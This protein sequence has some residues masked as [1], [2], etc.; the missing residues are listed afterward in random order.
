MDGESHNAIEEA[1]EKEL[2]FLRNGEGHSFYHGGLKRNVKVYVEVFASLQDQPERRKANY[3]MLGRSTYTAQ[4]G[5][6][7]DF[8]AVASGIT[9]CKNC[10]GNNYCH[11]KK[12]EYLVLVMSVL[13]GILMHVVVYLTSIHQVAIQPN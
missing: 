5:L 9:A 7:M 6:S 13:A 8:A 4:F 11:I 2:R 3:I 10:W 12:Q 1:V